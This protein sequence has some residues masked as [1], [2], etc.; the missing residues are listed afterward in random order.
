VAVRLTSKSHP[1]RY[2]TCDST[3]PSASSVIKQGS[4][5]E[6]YVPSRLAEGNF[7]D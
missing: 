1:A 2:P 3:N 5:T 7:L 6:Q 4:I